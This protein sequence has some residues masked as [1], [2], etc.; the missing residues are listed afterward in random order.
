MAIGG[1]QKKPFSWTC[2]KLEEGTA[3][4]LSEQVPDLYL[5]L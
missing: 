1:V 5:A 2:M 3:E 4:R